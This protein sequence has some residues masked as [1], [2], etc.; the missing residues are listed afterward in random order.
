[1]HEWMFCEDEPGRAG[2]LGTRGRNTKQW[3]PCSPPH[4]GP[5][6]SWPRHLPAMGWGRE[7][8]PHLGLSSPT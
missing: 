6:G 3:A 4:P 5:P 2:L 1:M 8:P 7:R